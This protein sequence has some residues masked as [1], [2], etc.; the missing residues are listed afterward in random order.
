MRGDDE[1]DQR[2]LEIEDECLKILALPYGPP[3]TEPIEV[4]IQ[5]HVELTKQ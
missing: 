3:A 1:I 2:E 4:S 5:T